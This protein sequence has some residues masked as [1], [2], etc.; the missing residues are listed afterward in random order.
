MTK[1]LLRTASFTDIHWGAKNNSEQ[2]NQD[3]LQYINWFCDNVRADPMIDSVVFMGDWYENRAAINVL[4]LDYSH[5]G[6][7]LLSELGLPIYFIVGNHDLYLRH[8]R[9][10]FSTVTFDALPNFNII[11]S[12]TI[13]PELGEGGALVTPYLFHDEYA[14][15]MQYNGLNTWWG[16]FEFQGFVVTGYSITLQ[17][18]PDASLFT[19]PKRIFSGHFHKRQ[20]NANVCY[21]GNTFPTSFG[22]AGDKN[23]GMM[24]YDHTKDKME[25]RNWPNAPYYMKTTLS[26]LLDGRVDLPE[27]SRVKCV[28]DVPITYEESLKMRDQFVAAYKLREFI[29]EESGESALAL[30]ETET[31]VDVMANTLDSVDDLVI[32]ML[33]DIESDQ[34]DNDTLIQ[35]FL[36][37]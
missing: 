24:I 20:I 6:A 5:A 7:K 9:D 4:T 22:D 8:T 23:R 2:H 10:T 26:A 14:S 29:T 11:S 13:V 17:E 12:P 35:Q 37:L 15:L 28:I 34:I 36:Q 1:Q 31:N 30:E 3:C 21:I 19:G 25:F 32:Q 18:G 33:Q 27:K 16:H